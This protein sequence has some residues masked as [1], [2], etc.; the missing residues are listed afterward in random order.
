MFKMPPQ[1]FLQFYT[2]RRCIDVEWLHPIY[3]T[4]K[5]YHVKYHFLTIW[6]LVGLFFHQLR[7]IR[8]NLYQDRSQIS[9]EIDISIYQ[10]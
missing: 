8:I 4:D 10:M 3:L 2:Y 6:I 7:N 5:I 9:I 1:D